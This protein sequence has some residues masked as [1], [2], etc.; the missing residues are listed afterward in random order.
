MT[1]GVQFSFSIDTI[2]ETA[3]RVIEVLGEEKI[4]IFEGQ[5]GAGKT[6]LIKAIGKELG[7]IDEMNSP[8]FGLVNEYKD[9]TDNSYYH[10]DFYRLD[11]PEEAL[12]IGVEEYFYSGRPCWIEWAGKIS[13]YLPDK[14]TIISLE[15][16]GA[17]ERRISIKEMSYDE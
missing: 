15:I 17:T 1:Q 16:L 7:I 12:D 10:F 8:T 6:T 5:M 3:R 11:K 14:F 4:W 2:S 13:E 9:S